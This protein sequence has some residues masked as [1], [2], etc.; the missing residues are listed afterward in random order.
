[1]E[2]EVP[3]IVHEVQFFRTQSFFFF[4]LFLLTSFL[5]GTKKEVI[6]GIT[7][8]AENPLE[9]DIE[10]ETITASGNALLSGDG[11]HLSAE[12]IIWDRKTSTVIAEG[13][14]ALGVIG[15]RL[16]AK[17]LILDLQSGALQQRM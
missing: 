17:S 8:K 7:L 2:N 15:Y 3:S 16:L 11:I 14:I 9:Y 1:M 13:K 6:Q 4:C 5:H 12:R 10:K